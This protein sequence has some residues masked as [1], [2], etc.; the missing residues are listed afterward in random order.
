MAVTGGLDRRAYVKQAGREF[1]EGFLEEVA[2]ELRWGD[3]S[4]VHQR[5]IESERRAWS[6]SWR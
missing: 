5:G 4:G 6:R 3:G 2:S 1:L